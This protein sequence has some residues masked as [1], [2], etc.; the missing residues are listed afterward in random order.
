VPP[1]NTPVPAAGPCDGIPDSPH[2]IILAVRANGSV[3][4]SNC[5]PP[6]TLFV[7]AADGFQP[8]E[9]VGVYITRPDQ[10]VNG[11]P[12]QVQADGNGE[13]DAVTFQTGTS[14]QQGIWAITF[15][16][17]SSHIRQIGYFKLRAP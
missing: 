1:T 2:V 8:N 15:E 6:G 5:E 14:S 4:E 16:G 3:V 9:S 11:A 7:F 17:V 12:F 10:S 13:T